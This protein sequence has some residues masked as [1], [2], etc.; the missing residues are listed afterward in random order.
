M[1]EFITGFNAPALEKFEN[2]NLFNGARNCPIES[3]QK[4]SPN[5]AL[6]LIPWS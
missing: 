5:A 1:Y 6:H 2:A 4:A 3:I